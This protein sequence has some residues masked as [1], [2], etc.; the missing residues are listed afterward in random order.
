MGIGRVQQVRS[1]EIAG[2]SG[3]LGT[4]APRWRPGLDDQ[5]KPDDGP[6]RDAHRASLPIP[7]AKSGKALMA[8]R[9]RARTRA[10]PRSRNSPRGNQRAPSP[11]GL[12]EPRIASQLPRDQRPSRGSLEA[13]K[14]GLDRLVDQAVCHGIADRDESYEAVAAA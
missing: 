7:Q 6:P 14:G 2:Q 1:D 8:A 11:S 3:R 9:R 13:A 5:P 12:V 10:R 4:F